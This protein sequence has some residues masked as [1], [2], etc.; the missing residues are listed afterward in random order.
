MTRS[1]FEREV[2]NMTLA[3]RELV[4]QTQDGVELHGLLAEVTDRLRRILE[5]RHSKERVTR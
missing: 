5:T 1:R 4:Q 3:R 2:I